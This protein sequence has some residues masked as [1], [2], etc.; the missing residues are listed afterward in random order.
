MDDG[1]VGVY[2]HVPF[3]ERVCPYCDFP[4]VAARRLAPR[5]EQSYVDAL[6]IELGLRRERFAGRTLASL[7]LGGG[8][9]S[10]LSPT[11][12]AR[13]VDAV[14]GAFSARPDLEV[15][16]EVNPSTTERGR[17]PD[18]RAAGV[19]R[20]SVGIQSFDDGVLKRLGRAHRAGE[21]R[22][23]LQAARRAGFQNLSLDL[24]FAAPGQAEEDLR[25]D[26][27]E[28][29]A[30]SP[31]HVSAYELTV[32]TGT[33]FALARERGQL[34]LASEDEALAMHALV[35][36]SL[37]SSGLQRYEISSYARPGQESQHNQRYWRR[38]PVLGIGMGAWSSDPASEVAPFGARRANLRQV[39]AYVASLAR[40]E[41]PEAG[42]PEV[43]SEGTARSEALFLALRTVRGLDAGGFAAEFGAPPRHF[44]A[45]ALN[46][47]VSL[48]LLVEDASGDL[49]LTAR[50][51]LLS[52]SVFEQF[53]EVSPR[54]VR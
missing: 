20:V 7:Y 23:T 27:S 51:R 31:E 38:L 37:G 2:V 22:A 30:F 44:H 53:V 33:P 19:N 42:P 41:L 48:G 4:V 52:D 18:F 12:V 9:P 3:C 34:A 26:L 14:T 28:V 45:E 11:S 39:G 49:R 46:A 25:R 13:I 43:L 10:L 32:E 54:R 50:G 29:V 24:L 36:Q 35:E 40:G 21:G 1:S 5:E 15:T 17:L 6:G 47:L 8:T 16:L